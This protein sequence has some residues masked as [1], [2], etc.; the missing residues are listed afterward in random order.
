MKKLYVGCALTQADPVWVAAVEQMKDS[1]RGTYEVLD[2][3][4]LI[5]GDETAVY[6]NDIHRNVA[7]CDLFVAICDLPSIGLGY[8]LGTAVEKHGK[9]VLAVAH[10]DAKVTRLVL[11]VDAPSFSFERYDNISDIPKLIAAKIASSAAPVGK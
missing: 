2:F 9:P 4:G 5:K 8:E 3:L 6:H 10:R 7:E 1:L 11:G